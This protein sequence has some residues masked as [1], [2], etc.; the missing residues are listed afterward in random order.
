MNNKT[1]GS[2]I[3]SA[4]T[5]L[6]ATSCC[7]IPWIIIAF[8]GSIGASAILTKIDHFSGPLLIFSALLLAL[9][10]YTYYNS[11]K[12]VS[13]SNPI[14]YISILTCPNCNNSKAEEMPADS[15][16]Y[17]YECTSCGTIL[18]PKLGDCC[19]FCSFGSIPCPPIQENKDCC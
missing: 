6:L 15:C 17:F 19:V 11:K 8:G 1:L 18:K 5:F 10:F 4:F 16:V 14:H 2:L 9:G 13:N 3:G 7:W 12:Q